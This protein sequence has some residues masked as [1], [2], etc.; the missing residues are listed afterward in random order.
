MP[1]SPFFSQNRK[2]RPESHLFEEI[3]IEQIKAFGQDV[4]YLPRKL[5]REDKLFGEDI[6]SEFNDSYVIE[7]YYENES[8]G[9]GEADALS[10]FGLELR[11]EAKFQVSRL[12]F[13]QLVALDENLISSI[14]PN[15]GDLIFFPSQNRKKLFEI[16]F[17][18]E[19]EF[20]R[21]HNIPVFTLTCKLFEYSNEALDTGIPEID[22]IEDT[23]STNSIGIYDL[24]LEDG[25]SGLLLESGDS[26]I[27]EEYSIDV[28]DKSSVNDWLQIESDKIIDFTDSNPFGEI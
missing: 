24:L 20:E 10:K 19:E 26:I 23:H 6:L 15:E 28:I 7:M 16:T 5:V 8:I 2:F 3:I 9:S 18:E 1:I 14:R 4:Y 13:D 25:T 12:R 21:L 27:Q 11:D 22:I 17:V